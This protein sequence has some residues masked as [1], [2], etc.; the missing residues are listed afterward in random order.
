[1]HIINIRFKPKAKYVETFRYTVD[2]FTEETRAGEGCLYFDWFRNTDYPGEYLVVGVWTD[3]GAKAHLQSEP[4]LRAQ[5]TLPP[6][7][8]QTPLIVQ[9]EFPHKKGWERF[10]DFAVN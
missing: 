1:M 6:L 3:E 7:L 2:K 10:S 8:Q 9:S 4:Y 5:E